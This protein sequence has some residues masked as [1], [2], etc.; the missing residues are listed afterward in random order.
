MD[1]VAQRGRHR[2]SDN[3]GP[4]A[5]AA[6]SSLLNMMPRRLLALHA[7]GLLCASCHIFIRSDIWSCIMT[8]NLQPKSNPAL[9]PAWWRSAGAFFSVGLTGLCWRHADLRLLRE[10]DLGRLR[11]LAPHAQPRA[12]GAATHL[13]AP[14]PSH[15]CVPSHAAK[16]PKPATL[17]MSHAQVNSMQTHKVGP[18]GLLGPCQGLPGLVSMK[19]QQQDAM[20]V[21]PVIVQGS[22]GWACWFLRHALSWRASGCGCRSL[23][24]S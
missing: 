5:G 7:T 10:H 2:C 16:G 4:P 15:Q 24:P 3:T 23:R 13:P 8:C 12:A 9:P 18:R 11:A 22:P 1:I 20:R 17:R 19:Q 21:V 6:L 14:L